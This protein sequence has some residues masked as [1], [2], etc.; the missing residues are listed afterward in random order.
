MAG[1]PDLTLLRVFAAVAEAK[2]FSGA[3]RTLGL[4]KSSVSRAVAR[5]EEELGVELLQRTT[6]VVSL[7]APGEFLLKRIAPHLSA[8]E[9]A[10]GALR[11]DEERPSGE[12][13]VAAASDV[14][15]ALLADVV[16]VF[17]G[18]YPQVNVDVRLGNRAVDLVAERFDLALR[19]HVRPL[20]SSSLLVRRVGTVELQLFAAPAYLA[21]EG[22]PRTLR[23][24]AR[25]DLVGFVGW[26]FEGGVGFAK[27]APRIVSDDLFFVRELL[28][29]GA[30]IGFLPSFFAKADV[31]SG[32][33]SRVLHQHS[34]R[35]A[36]LSLVFPRSRHPRAAALAFRTLLVEYFSARPLAAL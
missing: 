28:R 23:D 29:R 25:H 19:A 30:G 3:A 13:R 14:G 32:A 10:A 7:G 34:R 31:A 35:Q 16:P 9:E 11:G 17:C 22:T 1:T 33:L 15:V 4:P 2:S 18:R 27:G 21:R 8:L 36:S 24:S 5:L 20:R 12:L 6:H 26:P